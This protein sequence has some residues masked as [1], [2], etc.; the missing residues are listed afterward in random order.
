MTD[1]N[2][3]TQPEVDAP[4]NRST[5]VASR[6]LRDRTFLLAA[7]VLLVVALGRPIMV[8][9]LEIW[10]VKSP[11]PWPDAVQVSAETWQNVAFPEA[12]GENERFVMV[13]GDGV[14][15]EEKDGIPDG[16][17]PHEEDMLELLKIGGPADAD[18]IDER[19]SNWYVS[20]TYDDT[21]KDGLGPLWLLAI[22]YYT[23][24]HDPVPH[25]PEVCL[26]AG[27]ASVEKMDEMEVH[28]PDLPGP[29]GEPFDIRRVVYA[30]TDP[31]SGQVARFVQYYVFSLNGHPEYNRY[32]VR[33]RLTNPFLKYAYFAKIQFGVRHPVQSISLADKQAK[34]F[35]EA[36]LPAALEMLPDAET[37]ERLNADGEK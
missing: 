27:G 6:V 28:F 2:E 36:A 10:L 1:P 3:T 7:G 25:V 15:R 30:Y 8:N 24:G 16:D 29:W 32:H 37:V 35:L 26:V 33:G 9:A 4:D 19:A 31:V 18:R 11:V 5:A 23:G 21:K 20:R 34:E 12:L 13:R 17:Q 14:L 22:E